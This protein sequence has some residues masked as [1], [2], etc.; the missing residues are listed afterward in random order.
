L[1]KISRA[2]H[3]ERVRELRQFIRNGL[4]PI[5]E[6]TPA[7]LEKTLEEFFATA[8]WK[9]ME[10]N[11]DKVPESK[12]KDFQAEQLAMIYKVRKQL[13]QNVKHMPHPPGGRPGLL[14]ADQK[15]GAR[16]EV[17]RLMVEE[18]M[19]L[20]DA[21]AWVARQKA[22]SLSTM[23]RCWRERPKLKQQTEK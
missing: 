5:L 17:G 16:K 3:E 9:K 20:R 12:M 6:N 2:Q 15:Q 23:R 10:A 22:V 13:A 4:T 11:V 8:S 19:E 1:A 7:P 18:G 14:T 21:L